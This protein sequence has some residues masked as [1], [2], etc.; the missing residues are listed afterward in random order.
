V[1]AP[2]L[3]VRSAEY[4]HEAVPAGVDDVVADVILPDTVHHDVVADGDRI[5]RL[6][7]QALADVAAR[8]R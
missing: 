5:A 1:A 2:T 7:E 3:I 8:R 4:R 6:V